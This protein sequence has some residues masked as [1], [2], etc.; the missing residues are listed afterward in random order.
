MMVVLSGNVEFSIDF[1]YKKK[2]ISIFSNSLRKNIQMNNKKALLIG[3]NYIG[4]ERQLNGCQND[5]DAVRLMLIGTFGFKSENIQMMKDADS[6][7]RDNILAQLRKLVDSSK[8]GDEL[9]VHYS[10]HG[11]TVLDLN[12]DEAGTYDET[13]VA[14]DMQLIVDDE[15]CKILIN[16]LPAG[17]KLRA[18]FDSCHSGSILDMPYI[19]DS[20]EQISV[21]NKGMVEDLLKSDHRIDAILISGCQDDQT[22]EDAWVGGIIKYEGAMTWG[23]LE[24]L[25]EHGF[26]STDPDTKEH[27]FSDSSYLGRVMPTWRDLISHLRVH[28]QEGDYTQVPQMSLCHKDQ[29]NQ[30]LDF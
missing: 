23:L 7:T 14:V 10:G 17:V 21:A 20:N 16:G 13:I 22:S 11:S 27:T 1:F 30:L 8:Y 18:V 24:T 26:L 12:G 9:Y 6:P 25:R 15:L 5:V 28:L 3:I 2:G 4:S 29:L 19:Y